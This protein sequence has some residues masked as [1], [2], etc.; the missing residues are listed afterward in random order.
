MGSMQR[1]RTIIIAL[2]HKV[3]QNGKRWGTV[4]AIRNADEGFTQCYLQAKQNDLSTR[5]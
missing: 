4:G 2:I 3:L 1:P 5:S